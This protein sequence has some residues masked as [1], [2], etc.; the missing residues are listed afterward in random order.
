M[1]LF[2]KVVIITGASGGIGAATAQ[3]L[4]RNGAT[5]VLS[6]RTEHDLWEIAEKVGKNSTLVVPSDVTRREDVSN[7]VATVE[8][9]F[10][11][12]DI[13]INNAGIG[14][15]SP[16]NEI[17]KQ[18]MESV[19]A[20]NVFGPMYCMQEV[21]PVMKANGGGM[22]LNISSM[23]TAVATKGSGG[24][25]ASKS[26]LNALSDAA[27]IELK[28]SNIRVVTVLPGL[29]A[30]KF[31]SHCLGHGKKTVRASNIPP[32]GISPDY[33]AERI[34]R[35]IRKEP[36]IEYMS[37]FAK[38]KGI[39]SSLFPSAVEQFIAEKRG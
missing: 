3:A 21:I 9:R 20:V 5:V 6:S 25:R 38:A 15:D 39:A 28:E 23:I 24:Y 2:G 4:V 37:L 35:A 33:V 10:D 36:R 26:A 34:I 13:L 19:F 14:L 22:I 32:K 31:F 8:A 11:R 17:L 30:T 29:T 27:R 18:D 16:V 12:V 7:L 1:N